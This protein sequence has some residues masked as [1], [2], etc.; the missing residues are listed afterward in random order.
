LH[1][2]RLNLAEH[3]AAVREASTEARKEQVEAEKAFVMERG[4]RKGQ[5]EAFWLE[6]ACE[7]G[8][9]LTCIPSRLHGTEVSKE[10]FVDNLQL[11]Y[12]LEPLAMSCMC[13]GCGQKMSVEHA[14]S[15]KV[16]GLVHIR[17]DEVGCGQ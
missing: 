17:H 5:R 4:L 2:K 15:C 12:N 14:L 10:E 1:S 11:H 3:R 8:I 9:W 6:K 13:D 7:A 16:G